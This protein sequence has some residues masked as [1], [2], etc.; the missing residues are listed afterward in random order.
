MAVSN[1]K[2]QAKANFGA[3]LNSQKSDKFEG[4]KPAARVGWEGPAWI[5]TFE[6]GLGVLKLLSSA[7]AIQSGNTHTTDKG[8]DSGLAGA[9]SYRP[10]INKLM[11]AG[12]QSLGKW[13]LSRSPIGHH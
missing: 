4:V 9:S 3:R 10:K 7:I 11:Q 1:H 5:E 8:S 2:N 13:I 12:S 6:P